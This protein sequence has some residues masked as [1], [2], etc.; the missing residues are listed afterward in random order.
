MGGLLVLATFFAPMIVDVVGDAAA[1]AALEETLSN[2]A[3]VA[4][5]GLAYGDD[6]TYGSMYAQFMLVWVILAFAVMNIMFVVRHTRKD[7][8]EGQSEMIGALPVGRSA[9]LFAVFV[10]TGAVNVLLALLTGGVIALFGVE[11]LDLKGSL[12]FGCALGANGLFFAGI[13]ALFAQLFSTAKSTMGA[14]LAVLGAAYLLRAI[15][16]VGS[17]VASEVVARISPLGLVERSEIYVNNYLWP[18]LALVLAGLVIFAVAFALGTRRDSG[19]G[20]LPARTGRTHA[21]VFLRGEFGLSW[22]LLRGTTLAWAAVVFIFAAAYGSVFGDLDAFVENNGM[23][24][25]MLGIGADKS[26][27]MD[28]VIATMTLVMSIVATIPVVTVALRLK[29][30]A[31]RGRVEQLLAGSVSRIHL[32]I[33]EVAIAVLLAG[34]LQ[35]L[36][37]LGMWSAAAVVMDEPGRF[38]LYLATAMS[39]LP[40]VLVFVGLS[41]LFLGVV[42]RLSALVWV[43]LAYSF[44]VSFLGDVLGL[45]TWAENIS[46]FSLLPRY[47]AADIEPARIAILCVASILLIAAGILAYRRRDLA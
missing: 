10:V 39:F 38:T 17:D 13:T 27:I 35:F 40:A 26:D 24:Q 8:E 23:Y 20:M 33:C 31:S 12:V 22:R 19:Q 43:Y 42:P 14:A 32:I 34:I 5:C 11:T 44:F 28:P 18:E 29:A 6:Y 36:T 41:I 37:A 46:V 7:E 2:P 16:D 25:A 4:M 21:S 15:G 3:M 9:N 1:Q 47:P 30:E 45:P